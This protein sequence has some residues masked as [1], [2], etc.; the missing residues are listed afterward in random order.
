MNGYETIFIT[1]PDLPEND[2]KAIKETLQKLVK[3]NKGNDVVFTDWGKR[4][5]SYPISKNSRVNYWY[6]CYTGESNLPSEIDRSLRLNDK[7]L[8]HMTVKIAD[9]GDAPILAKIA[10][11]AGTF[12]SREGVGAAEEY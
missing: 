11:D 12:V 10:K 7:V 1:P 2:V 9:Q 6:Y 5:L 8:R 4:R 3:K